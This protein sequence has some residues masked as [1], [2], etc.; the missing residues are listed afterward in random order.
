MVSR[1]MKVIDKVTP[2][3]DG[4]KEVKW[5]GC[6]G[7]RSPT[8]R[9]VGRIEQDDVCGMSNIIHSSGSSNL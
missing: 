6:V 9:F 5:G 7:E 8:H 1:A 4:R 2:L 3:Q